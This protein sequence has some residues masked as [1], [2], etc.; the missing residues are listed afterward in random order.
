MDQRGLEVGELGWHR[1]RFGIEQGWMTGDRY[2][3]LAAQTAHTLSGMVLL[4]IVP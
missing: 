2:L 1:G 4:R 3:V